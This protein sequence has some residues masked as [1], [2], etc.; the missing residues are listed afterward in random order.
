M[1]RVFMCAAGTLGLRGWAI[2]EMPALRM[3]HLLRA[4]GIC[5][6]QS[7]ETSPWTVETCHAN[8]LEHP[9]RPSRPW[10]RRCR[11][12]GPCGPLRCQGFFSNPARGLAG[13]GPVPKARPRCPEPRAACVPK[14]GE[15]GSPPISGRECLRCRG[16]WQCV[17]YSGGVASPR[18]SPALR[19]SRGEEAT[20]ELASYLGER[21]ED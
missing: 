11:P 21:A 20:A 2:S 1:N 5:W 17:P 10:C 16:F 4:P 15:P 7:G 13:I 18:S 3:R 19:L 8:L 6:R 14:R 9:C 12:R